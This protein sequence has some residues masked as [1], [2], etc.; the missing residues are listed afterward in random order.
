M[1]FFYVLEYKIRFD[2]FLQ[3]TQRGCQKSYRKLLKNLPTG[4]VV[5]D[6]DNNPILFNR[7]VSG[8]I[9]QRYNEPPATFSRADSTNRPELKDKL[10]STLHSIKEIGRP[11]ATLK[12]VVEGWREYDLEDTSKKY[13]YRP[14]D[15]DQIFTIR[16]ISIMFYTTK[17]RALILQ[18][19]SAFE[20]LARLEERYQKL[21]VASI[22]HDIRT[23][24]NGIIGMLEMMESIKKTK[25]QAQYL[26]VAQRTCR[27]LLFITYDITDYSQ[28]EANKF[29]P[30]N[31]YT[32][33]R[34]T[35]NE[36][37]Q[38]MSFSFE[39]KCLTTNFF[40]DDSV[41]ACVFIDRNRYTQILL[42]FV[43][44][45]VKF[46]FKGGIKVHASCDHT[47][48]MLL[49][50]VTDT[51][52][53]IGPEDMPRLFTLFGKL[54]SNASLNPQGVGFGL[55][56]CKRLSESLGGFVRAESVPGRG[57]MF[58]FG[59]KANLQRIAPDEVQHGEK[60]E[61][62]KID[63]SSRLE[64]GEIEARVADH[65]FIGGKDVLITRALTV[66]RCGVR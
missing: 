7:V 30:N 16:G 27:L 66:S 34:D 46:T 21:Y 12:R 1:S 44:N 39:K 4:I 47:G 33:I 13:C 57:S 51:G 23:P 29:K 11:E 38:L 5:L 32:N 65:N 26:S 48:D 49:T 8:L 25:E 55:A 50:S 45:A 59:I 37:A 3:Y 17:C 24:L 41:P 22:V 52:V 54:E 31:T 62:E 56:V 63:V 43:G 58:S 35:I 18:D 60:E 42:N 2:F 53:G 9:A 61:S 36:V 14:G 15:T 28:L 10:L 64:P 40:A 6:C 19:Q 20:Q